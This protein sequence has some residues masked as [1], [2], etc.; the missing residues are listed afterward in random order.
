ML[1]RLL[2]FG[3]IPTV[4]TT[5]NAWIDQKVTDVSPKFFIHQTLSKLKFITSDSHS[6]IFVTRKNF[7][8]TGKEKKYKSFNLIWV[9]FNLNIFLWGRP[10]IEVQNVSK[11]YFLPIHQFWINLLS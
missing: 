3:S 1:V 4:T 10:Q 8:S 5:T 11:H 6:A 9:F 2:K 7:Y